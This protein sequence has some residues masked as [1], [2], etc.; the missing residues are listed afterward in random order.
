MF[1]F[2]CIICKELLS[3]MEVI[4]CPERCV[5]VSGRRESGVCCVGSDYEDHAE[6]FYDKCSDSPHGHI[7]AIVHFL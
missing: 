7:R 2:K 1:C 5:L 6:T 4:G 3:K